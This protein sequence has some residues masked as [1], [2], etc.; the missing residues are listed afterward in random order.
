MPMYRHST[1]RRRPAHAGRRVCAFL[2]AGMLAPPA[3]A[4]DYAAAPWQLYRDANP[5]V[6]ASG[7]PFAPPAFAA[8][9]RWHVEATLAA[10]NTEIAFDHGSERLLYDM[11]VH[12]ARIAVARSFGTRWMVRATLAGTRFEQGFLDGFI[13]D[14]HRLFGFSQGDRDDLGRHGSRIQYTDGQGESVALTHA[15][16]GVAP[17][18]IDV[19][20]RANAPSHEW[21]LGTTLK[22]PISHATVLLDDRSIDVSAWAGLQSTRATRW[23]W[24]L[25]AGAMRRGD[26]D[27]LP[28]RSERIVPF[29][30]A[31]LGWQLT[32]RWQVAAQ[33]QWHGAAYRSSIPMLSAAGSLAL[34]TAWQLPSGWTWRA[35]LVED[36]PARHS[37]DVTFFVGL[38]R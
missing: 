3:L 15:R 20:W 29:A 26:G 25:R 19:V 8:D 30:D 34:S 12:E 10:S 18:L 17:L 9:G 21:L 38:A 6:A 1:D 7:L 36:V 23:R 35:G 31:T 37:Q 33:Y 32:P 28:Q 22:L 13:E 4:D 2:I 24:G 5:F 27:L 16:S 11:E 14:F